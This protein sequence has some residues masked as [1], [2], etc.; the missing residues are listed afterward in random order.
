MLRV[1]VGSI[2]Q[3]SDIGLFLADERGFFRAA[4]IEADFVPFDTAAKQIA[5]L[6][7]GQLDVGGGALSAGLYNAVSRH[8]PIKMVADKGSFLPG[9][10][11]S[12]LVV[13][14]DLAST[15]KS[16]ADLKGHTI[17]IT[18]QGA[19]PDFAL[20]QGLQKAQLTDHDVTL[21][22]MGAPDVVAAMKNKGI[23]AAIVTEPQVTVLHDQKLAESLARGDQLV[24]NLQNAVLLY[25]GVWAAA[26][27][28]QAQGF[29]E[30]YL[31]GVRVYVD[32]FDRGVD[33]AGVVQTLA[34]Y[35]HTQDASIFERMISP[36][37]D[38]DGQLHVPSMEAML[39]WFKQQQY[40]QDP[41]VTVADA[42]D[43]SYAKRAVDTLGPAARS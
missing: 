38:P 40:V 43:E 30:A 41:N 26:H 28:A 14:S 12:V 33:K 25:S 42:I 29:M 1:K 13:R 17:A 31:R 32:A 34:K 4:G 11:F 27:P 6:G 23:D 9:H 15:M 24:P 7:A 10:G 35:T 21:T 37:L 36:G 39:T 5:P 8:V 3:S 22:Q 19:S 16:F 20:A 18:S 2:G